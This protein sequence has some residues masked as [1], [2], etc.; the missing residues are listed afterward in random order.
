[1]YHLKYIFYFKFINK[2]KK[3]IINLVNLI[4]FKIEYR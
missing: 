1:M 3:L 2:I 4:K